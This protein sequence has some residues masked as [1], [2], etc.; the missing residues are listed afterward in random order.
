MKFQIGQQLRHKVSGEQGVCK[1]RSEYSTE[2]G[3]PQ[4][5]ISYRDAQ[6]QATRAWWQESDLETVADTASS[7]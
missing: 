3:E 2:L 7:N 4:Y 6:G 1:G 5:F